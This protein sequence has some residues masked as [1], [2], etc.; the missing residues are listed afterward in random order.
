[1]QQR[2]ATGNTHVFDRPRASAS[3]SSA[4]LTELNTTLNCLKVQNIQIV[5]VCPTR[6]ARRR[7]ILIV[8]QDVGITGA[9]EDLAP[10]DQC[11]L[12][13]VMQHTLRI[14]RF[15]SALQLL[16]PS[17]S[18]G[19]L[20]CKSAS[21][22]VPGR[23]PC[24][25]RSLRARAGGRK[26]CDGARLFP[27]RPLTFAPLQERLADRADTSGLLKV[28]HARMNRWHAIVFRLAANTRSAG[29]QSVRAGGGP[30]HRQ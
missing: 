9:A 23:L 10:D 18:L 27:R 6:S 21:C 3:V 17:P 4:L 2:Q 16:T 24:V 20:S 8:H 12:E 30:S 25:W 11:G 29:H 15:G 5:H 28:C 7:G 1:V 26:R 13:E 19:H 14:C 22:A